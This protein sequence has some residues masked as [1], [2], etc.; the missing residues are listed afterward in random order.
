MTDQ[1][2]FQAEKYLVTH[3]SKDYPE[4][5]FGVWLS[6]RA[7]SLEEFFDRYPD[8]KIDINE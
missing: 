5:D 4:E 3:H 8:S 6:C 1:Q 2:A 7:L